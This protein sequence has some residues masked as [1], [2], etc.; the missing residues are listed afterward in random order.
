MSTFIEHL[1][2]HPAQHR[3]ACRVVESGDGQRLLLCDERWLIN[4]MPHADG[5]RQRLC[6]FAQAGTLPWYRSDA[7]H[8]EEW[9][10]SY[11][12]DR[13]SAFAVAINAESGAVVLS[14]EHDAA[15]LD[16]AAFG[17]ALDGFVARLRRMGRC[18]SVGETRH[19]MQR[20]T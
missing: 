8:G 14:A 6:I 7:R 13:S 20:P 5:D 11:G 16:A 2:D 4:L 1:L 15:D 12:R 9:A 18:F 10:E 19:S 3:D 17:R